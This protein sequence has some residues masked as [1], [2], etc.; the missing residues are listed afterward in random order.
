MDEATVSR[1]FG[2]GYDCSQI[3]LSSVADRLGITRDAALAAASGLGI[4]LCRGSVCGAALGGIVAIGIRYGNVSP[5]DMVSKSLVF[6]KREEFLTRFEEANSSILCRDLI[7]TEVSD[8]DEMIS[9][10]PKGVYADCPKY[11]VNAVRILEDLISSPD[12]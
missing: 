2:E 7:G 4:G 5:G 10:S 11:C 8:L 12:E 1:M 3:V 6:G 9:L